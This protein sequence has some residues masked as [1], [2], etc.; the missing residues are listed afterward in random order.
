[1][2]YIAECDYFLLFIAATHMMKY[3]HVIPGNFFP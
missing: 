3:Q 1:M 2:L